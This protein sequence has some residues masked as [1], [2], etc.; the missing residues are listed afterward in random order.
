M[1]IFEKQ[2]FY[3]CILML[4]D[5]ILIAVEIRCYRLSFSL[6]LLTSFK[7]LTSSRVVLEIYI[8][9][10][11]MFS[12]IGLIIYLDFNTKKYGMLWTEFWW[13]CSYDMLESYSLW[14]LLSAFILAHIYCYICVD[15][16]I[17]NI[18]LSN[19]LILKWNQCML[20]FY[21]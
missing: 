6:S 20:T 21:I 10:Y 11:K 2:L 16:V 3:Y 12:Q 4:S 15:R 5:N 19:S 13:S 18:V 7:I 14:I 1:G 9:C 8:S 17:L